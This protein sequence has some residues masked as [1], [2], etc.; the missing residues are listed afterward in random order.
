MG[1][2][3]LSLTHAQRDESTNIFTDIFAES[4]LS[5]NPD[6]DA[7][8]VKKVFENVSLVLENEDLGAAFYH[9]LTAT[10][11]IKLI[12]FKD[13]SNNVFHVVTELTYKKGD[14]EFR[15]DITLLINGMPLAFIE[16]K[17]PNNHEGILAE[18]DRINVRF[19]NKKFRKFI[20]ISQIL[21]FS[22]NMEYDLESIEPIQGA[23]Y[24]STSY[25][26]AN[27][28]CF[29]EEE[30]LDLLTL[31]AP[32]DNELENDV[33]KDTNLAAIKNTP[34]FKTNKNPNSPTNRLLTSLF[35]K[36]RLALLLKYGLAYVQEPKGLEKHIMR[37][38]QLFAT[39]AIKHTLESGVKK[40][41][42]WHTQGSGKTALS[43]YNV[44]YLTDYF[45]QKSIVPQFYFIVDRI[46]LMDQ[47]KREFSSRGLIVHGI[48][49]KEELVKNFRLKQ[50]VHNL[51]GKRE[52]TVVNI[53]KFKD[54]S[55]VLKVNDYDISSQRIYFLDEVHRSYNPT[56]SFLANLINSDKNA[57]II[58][59]TGTPLIANDRRSRDTFGD[60]IHKYYYNASIADGYTLKLIREGIE[61]KYQLEL[62]Q[63]LKEIE[64]LKG[65][66]DKRV[67]Y[68]H[69]KFV[70]PLLDYIID[71]FVQSR[72]RLGDHTLGGM[73]V[74][75]SSNQA[76]K[77][78]EFFISKYHPEQKTLQDIQRHA[79]VAEPSAHYGNYQTLHKHSLTASLILHDFGNKA[80]RKQEVADFKDGKIDLL[81]VY[82]MLLT[83]FDAKRLKKLYIGRV[84]KSHN[85]LQALTR[86][87]RPYK[88]FKYGYVVDFADIRKEFDTTNKAYFAELQD[89][90]GD[91]MENYS[92]LFK[93]KA[94]IEAEIRDI[95][96]NLFHYDLSNAENFSQQISQIQDRKK[97]L[98]IKKA[99][100][101][102][103]NLYN[104]IRL[105]GHFDILE[106]VDFKKLNQLYNETAR[107]LELLNLKESLQNNVDTTNLLNVA[108]E[109]VLFMFRKVSEEEMIIADQ[110]KDS[111][112]KTRETL[113]GNFDQKDP[114]F[115]SLYDELK[116]LFQKKN[117]DEITQDDMKH[118][119]EALQKILEAGTE[120]NR[121]NNLLKAKYDN[122][123]KYAR[124]H[125]RLLEKG[126]I[127]NRESEIGVT[128]MTIKQQA[129]HKILI[130][131]KLLDN[132]SYFQ[133]LMMN[134]VFDGFEKAQI[135]LAPETALYIND[136]LVK[137]YINEYQGKTAWWSQAAKNKR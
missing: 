120:L 97:V 46:D 40:G 114:E 88:N 96:D 101:N 94:E 8:A 56:G 29:R 44:H 130:N 118:N 72:N 17:K 24:A 102:A 63:A 77:L 20:N 21:V 121:K 122:D 71:D 5:I 107:H 26:N 37:Y 104:L 10:S 7:D 35:C 129:D 136:C 48:N 128:L 16:V 85:L 11:G 92:N 53:Q 103:K 49:S 135:D 66:T 61:T 73:V 105:S 58:G 45:Q 57:I 55:D 116:R 90:L 117:L 18:R 41:I 6:T 134:V 19:K 131:T 42:I 25:S 82:N 112:R 68:A 109:N 30:A 33:L 106:T 4:L 64:I 111:L 75:D 115:I 32:E 9:L 91:E 119:R 137:E 59:L 28:N 34:E 81:F 52:I 99:L 123:S 133:N 47:A 38:P 50:A 65:N 78:F 51:S 124:V 108:L 69:E 1:Y 23:F 113:G 110:L 22:N 70:E 84:I 31:L 36:D 127:T 87:N 27:F 13:F 43:F 93:S 132:E 14:E 86:V 12:D 100:E 80:D 74:C 98:E 95:K 62:Q 15:P 79:F 2:R 39:Q 126:A 67:I 89:E 60:Y 3:Y 76:K 83:G 125:K 54:D